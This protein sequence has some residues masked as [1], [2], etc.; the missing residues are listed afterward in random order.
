MT[1]ADRPARG[2]SLVV[3]TSG[4]I[5]HGKSTLVRALTG[6]D[7]DRLA[8]EKRRGIT[9][10]LGFA[11]LDGPQGQH[12]AFVDV[13]GHERFVHNMLAGAAGMDAVLLVVAADRGVMPQTLEHLHICDLLGL[14]RG[15]VVLTRAD[16]ADADLLT[17]SA[18]EVRRATAGTFLEQAP[19]LAVSA[20]TGQGLP[21][22][23]AALY[24]LADGQQQDAEHSHN[25]ALPFRLPVDRV[26]TLK[27]FGTVVTG[28]ALAGHLHAEDP[29]VLYPGGKPVRVR[30]M[31]VQGQAATQVAAGQ[32]VAL[33]LASMDKSQLARGHQLA[34]PESL[35]VSHMLNTRLHLLEGLAQELGQRTRVRLHLGTA[36]VLGRLVLLE[37]ESLAPGQTCWVQV[38]LEQP[39]ASRWG[40]RFIV[41]SY[42]P[43]HTLGGGVVIDP[44]PIKARRLRRHLLAGLEA[45][46]GPDPRAR[47]EQAVLLQGTR[48]ML[49]QEGVLR[50]GLPEK[51]LEKQVQTLSSQGVLVAIAPTTGRL[52]HAAALERIGRFLLRQLEQQHL[53]HPEREGLTL[54][55]LAPKLSPLY[56]TP[57][58]GQMLSRLAKLGQL[59]P[60]GQFWRLPGHKKGLGTQASQAQD[61]LLAAVAA[62]GLQPPRKSTLLAQVGLDDKIGTPLLKTAAHQGL[63][64]QIKEDLYYI[65]SA[66]AHMQDQLRAYLA[67]NPTISVIQFKDLLNIPRKHAVDVLEYCDAQRI[68]LRLGN[69]RVLRGK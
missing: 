58:V 61:A 3:G 4:H 32:R 43:M 54:P 17:L 66:L 15:L 24:A 52:L 44:Q 63:L 26:F 35:L 51:Q 5:D 42:S 12:I 34:A 64:V 48:G 13:P 30:G 40:D 56:S 41:R 29:L 21:E 18:E 20:T 11:H 49:R 37:G 7:P 50:T 31:Q 6:T 1:S 39:V 67:Q 28:T 36:E 14:R 25:L 46:G 59:V 8:E 62:G 53:L 69:E 65:P 23:K 45:L 22:L 33:N 10:D 47:V 38:R 19:I 27:G 60:E 68:T 16:L 57:E 2:V 55:E 9:I